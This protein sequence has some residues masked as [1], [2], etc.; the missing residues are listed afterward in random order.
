MRLV[1]AST[2]SMPCLFTGSG[3]FSCAIVVVVSETVNSSRRYA[4]GPHRHQDALK[5]VLRRTGTFRR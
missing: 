1:R 5:S 2:F 4:A 3:V